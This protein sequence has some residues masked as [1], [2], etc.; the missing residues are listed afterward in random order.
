MDAIK[1]AQKSIVDKVYLPKD[2]RDKYEIV[3]EDGLLTFK[4]KLTKEDLTFE[5][6]EDALLAIE[7]ITMHEIEMDEYLN[8]DKERKLNE[9]I[10]RLYTL[11][12]VA[13]IPICHD[14]H[15]KWEEDLQE[16]IKES[17]KY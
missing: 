14:K 12:H 9:V 3:F 11:S 13:R 4:K 6:L 8:T 10:S 2:I 7:Y 17:K 5:R 15:E 1:L 16:I